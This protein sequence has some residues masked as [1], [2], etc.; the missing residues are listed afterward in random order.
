VSPAD[1]TSDRDDWARRAA[2]WER[3]AKESET[4]SNEYNGALID[5]AGIATGQRVLDLAAGMGDPTVSIAERIGPKGFVV[6]LDRSPA[7]LAGGRRRAAQDNLSN[8]GYLASDM[9]ALPFADA[10]FDA[11]TCRYG[12]MFPPDRVAAAA[13]AR[14]VL[15]PGA[16][17]A[18][19][20]WGPY[21]ENTI[22]ATVRRTVLNFFGEAGGATP[23][24]RHV[25]GVAGTLTETLASAGFTGVAERP[26][27][28][29]TLVSGDGSAWRNRLDRTYSERLATLDEARRA[30]LDRALLDAF[31]PYREGDGYRITTHA[32]IGIATAPGG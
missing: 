28:T 2:A 16:K 8:I 22:Y 15:K 13:E 20:V 1:S 18:F 27:T 29:S 10:A 32:K 19:L 11:V 26:I 6:A 23:P 21:E 31:Q 4:S 3:T 12:L 14:R 7:M 30:D 9:T 24:I 5:G 17:A 25:F